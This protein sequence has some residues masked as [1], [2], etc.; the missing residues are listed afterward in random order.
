VDPGHVGGTLTDPQSW[1]GYAYA[2]NNPLRFA[3]P[4]GRSFCE[5]NP[6][7]CPDGTVHPEDITEATISLIMGRIK[8]GIGEVASAVE[9]AVQQFHEAP[10]NPQCMAALTSVGAGIGGGIGAMAGGGTGGTAGAVGA[11]APTGGVMA[12]PGAVLGATAGAVKGATIGI[13]AGGIAGSAVGS[14][15]CMTGGTGGGSGGGPKVPFEGFQ[16]WGR[17]LWGRGV[18]GAKDAINRMTRDLA[19]RID[20]EKAQMAREF[21]RE[22]EAAGKGAEAARFRQMLMD[23][24]LQLQR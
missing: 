3:D 7:W 10:R 5:T 9:Q 8:F 12:I 14:V 16:E 2:G 23:R 21:Y 19:L 20:P 1:N 15:A 24:I 22:A 4:D 18:E 11:G 13:V 17:P 6:G